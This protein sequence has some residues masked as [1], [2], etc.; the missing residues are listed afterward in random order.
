MKNHFG[1]LSV[2]QQHKYFTLKAI[3][4]DEAIKIVQ[5]LDDR[6][7]NSYT[8]FIDKMNM[9]LGDLSEDD[10]ALYNELYSVFVLG[11]KYTTNEIIEKVTQA[12]V[13]L[14][15][16]FYRSKVRQRCESV[17]FN[18]FAVEDKTESTVVDG[19]SVMQHVGYV[20]LA[21]TKPP[22]VN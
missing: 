13:K 10:R 17:F 19:N 3:Y 8:A 1:E 18:M 2:P 14:G 15:L 6:G 21:M 12:R 4:G 11:V 9:W 7:R 22:H 20:P 16:D 5:V